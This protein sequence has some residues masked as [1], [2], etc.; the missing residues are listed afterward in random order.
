MYMYKLN[1]KMNSS[2]SI[3]VGGSWSKTIDY[4]LPAIQVEEFIS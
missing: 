2:M 4:G 3:K 1:H